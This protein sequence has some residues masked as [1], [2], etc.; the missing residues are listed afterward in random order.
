MDYAPRLNVLVMHEDAI[1]CEGLAAVLRDQPGLS[2]QLR[3]AGDAVRGIEEFATRYSTMTDDV[4]DSLVSKALDLEAR[5]TALKQKYYTRVKAA[6]SPK[7]AA[8][9]LQI[10]NQLLMLIDLQVAASLPII[11]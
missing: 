8:R 10:E 2:V 7:V 9:F 3:H 4:A 6:T 11:Q 1:V 5:R